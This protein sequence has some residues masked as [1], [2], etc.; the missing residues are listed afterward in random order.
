MVGEGAEAG[1]QG[2]CER[3]GGRSGWWLVAVAGGGRRKRRRGRNGMEW[4]SGGKGPLGGGVA[5]RRGPDSIV[6]YG[7]T[8]R[9]TTRAATARSLG[10]LLPYPNKLSI[11]V[12][13]QVAAERS[14]RPDYPPA[15][16]PVSPRLRP[17]LNASGRAPHALRC[18]QSAPSVHQ[19]MS[20][21][22]QGRARGGGR[23]RRR[24]DTG[25]TRSQ[26]AHGKWVRANSVRRMLLNIGVSR[27][28]GFSRN[29]PRILDV[30]NRGRG[31]DPGSHDRCTL[32]ACSH[33]KVAAASAPSGGPSAACGRA[34][35]PRSNEVCCT[36]RD[37]PRAQLH[38][39]R[40]GDGDAALGTAMRRA[41]VQ[42]RAR[43]T[44]A[45]WLLSADVARRACLPA[46]NSM[47]PPTPSLRRC[48]RGLPPLASIGHRD[49]PPGLCPF[50]TRHWP[51]A[52]PL[53]A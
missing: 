47:L 37:D 45:T 17:L 39:G 21:P 14:H 13:A 46:R 22:A 42:R 53:S 50:A 29:R 18:V 24:T 35:G 40:E 34:G 5:R 20:R 30:P 10:L 12:S 31:G 23:G 8:G 2:R 38:G 26:H 11:A 3:H 51:V 49:A 28:S 27:R 25:G 16:D 7:R 48:A 19:T 52:A 33:V 41:G 43:G 4:R 44:R 9:E 36:S 15:P 6:K 32:A 1:G